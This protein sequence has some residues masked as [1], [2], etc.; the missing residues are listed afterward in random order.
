MIPAQ[1][2]LED[3][4]ILFGVSK[5]RILQLVDEGVIVRAERNQYPLAENVKAMIRHAGRNR[6]RG[7]KDQAQARHTELKARETE[8]RVQEREGQ[9]IERDLVDGWMADLV[10]AFRGELTGLPVRY[11]RDLAERR[12]LE[13][14]VNGILR[15]VADR[16]RASGE[17]LRD[18]GGDAD[19]ED[20]EA[21]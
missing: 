18:G 12:R 1:C 16:L 15:R 17:A 10:G 9:L 2:G 14:E 4:A 7:S 21:A 19:P 11:T 5:H 3:L 13:D 8:L 20:E 6:Q